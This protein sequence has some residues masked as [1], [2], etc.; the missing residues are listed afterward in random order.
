MIEAKI[1]V[2]FG[3]MLSVSKDAGYIY[4]GS[5]GRLKNLIK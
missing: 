4:F 3:K 2:A 5:F 1:K